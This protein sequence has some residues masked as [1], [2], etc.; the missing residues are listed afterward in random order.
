M[1]PSFA[2]DFRA[3][4]IAL[5][6]RTQRGWMQVGEAAMDAPD[7]D[8]ALRYLRA[9]ALG[10]SP[11]GISTKLVIPNDQILYTTVKVSGPDGAKRRRAIGAALEG[12][13][14]YPVEDLVYDWAGSGPDLRVAVIARET[15][16]E[17][18][19]FAVEHRFNPISFVAIPEDARFAREPWFG[20]TAMAQALLSE[21]EE[22]ER[23]DA[24]IALVAR[25]L[26]RSD[27]AASA[28]APAW[29]EVPAVTAE[30]EMAKVPVAAEVA[31][32]DPVIVPEAPVAEVAADPAPDMALMADLLTAKAM[33]ERAYFNPLDLVEE[34]P[35]ALDVPQGDA[36]ADPAA[37]ATG[38]E[39]A[40]ADRPNVGVLNP[41][42]DDELPPPPSEAAL[43]AFASRR[44][45]DAALAAPAP[46]GKPGWAGDGPPASQAG[47]R[48]V[49]EARAIP[50][51]PALAKPMA[52][53]DPAVQRATAAASRAGA[54]KSGGSTA[55]KALRGLGGLG[56]LVGSG[57]GMGGNLSGRRAK[58][59]PPAPARPV[60][61]P[62]GVK[63]LGSGSAASGGT[64]TALP[65][66]VAVPV[67]DDRS[68][69]ARGGVRPQA[70]PGQKPL[71]GL[72]TKPLPPP[73]PRYLGLILTGI[74]LVFLALVAAWST[75]FLA[76]LDTTPA[77]ETDVA[78][79]DFPSPEDEMAADLQA[80]A[81]FEGIDAAG[82]GDS[83]TVTLAEPVPAAGEILADAGAGADTLPDAAADPALDLAAAEPLSEAPAV[84]PTADPV[85]DFA[86]A[87]PVA[88][89]SIA[90]PALES[91]PS[92]E[93]APALE[94]A[95]AAESVPEPEAAPVPMAEPEPAP[96]TQV[97]SDLGRASAPALAAQDEIF[98]A[99]MDAPPQT[100]DPGALVQ[101][102]AAIDPPP[103]D[104]VPPPPFGTVYR[105]DADGRIVAT[106]E[107]IITPEGVLLFAGQPPLLPP[108]R[109]A[110][111]TV[112]SAPVPAVLPS[113]APAPA[114]ES[115]PAETVA[116]D[117]IPRG[118]NFPSDP[119]LAGARPLPRP[120]DLAPPAAQADDD[121]SAAPASD[122]RFASL[123]PQS[124]PAALTVASAVAASQSASLVNPDAEVLLASASVASTSLMA[125]AVSRRPESRP[126]DL[127]NAV[128]AA[129]AAAT[130]QP[131]P[132]PEQTS[133]AQPSAGTSAGTSAEADA[134]PELA[135][136]APAVPTRASVAKQATYVNAINLSKM[137]LIG[138]Y[139]TS[140]N[141]YALVRQPNGRYK[142]VQVGDALDGGKVAAITDNELRYQKG[143]R[144]LTL[145]LPTG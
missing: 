59:S 58:I 20:P 71:T 80:P 7:L 129:V 28:D 52:A 125:V 142:K 56:A 102:A 109:P 8:D 76:A 112:A 141:R 5:L 115:V 145:E 6:H 10:L 31:A 9:T 90:A 83:E 43:T 3:S 54:V 4:T 139:G 27:G 72:G 48:I 15:L 36:P 1:K 140:S 67:S 2:L 61:A 127:S 122:S 21:G 105:F 117:D 55:G 107:G 135:S 26:P 94:P 124:R 91:A 16:A 88:E 100:A 63:S 44:A 47:L 116:G 137:N 78:Q 111:L 32:V 106:P 118:E 19:A 123:R 74:L 12:Q 37:A 101:V 73:R 60:V 53:L 133:A 85:L 113:E 39:S 121:A 57:A 64:V 89:A 79:S 108:S 103:D 104:P 29:A 92:S 51:R 68:D 84:G 144:M 132:E 13:T 41:G 81:E 131:E 128:E 96:G 99:A 14:P 66:A 23:D 114:A 93:P 69:A 11:R 97:S 34:A 136:A 119:A 87:E 38:F 35:I 30:P 143:G 138:V 40:P 130:R 50:E 98:L 25:E 42:I 65:S 86:A 126:T 46:L 33:P 110:A 75:F 70:R 49:A 120:A 45:G 62:A 17:A 18:E 22:V 82:S 95:P 77:V 24:P 134:E